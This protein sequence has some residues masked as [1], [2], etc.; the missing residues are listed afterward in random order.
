MKTIFIAA[1]SFYRNY[2]S[3]FKLKTCRYHPS[4]SQYALEAIEKK[5]ALVSAVLSAKRILRCHPFS[6]GGYDPVQ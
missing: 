5:G 4:C 1:I 6:R 3:A 2:L